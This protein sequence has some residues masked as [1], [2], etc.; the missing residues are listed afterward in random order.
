MSP[1]AWVVL[2]VAVALVAMLI[3]VPAAFAQDTTPLVPSG[4]ISPSV[5]LPTAALLV[6][7]G[8]LAY[9]V[10]RRR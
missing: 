4:G 3:L 5:I 9:T 2:L 6:G 7:A 8:I 10:S 1:E